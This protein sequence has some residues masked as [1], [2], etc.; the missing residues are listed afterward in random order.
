MIPFAVVF[1]FRFGEEKSSEESESETSSTKS[2]GML[3]SSPESSEGLDTPYCEIFV[4]SDKFG[5]LE[6]E[7]FMWKELEQTFL[8]EDFMV[9]FADVDASF[10]R[11]FESKALDF[12]FAVG[13]S[14]V[15]FF[16]GRPL[17]L[18]GLDA[19][20]DSWDI[21]SLSP[22]SPTADTIDSR[23]SSSSTTMAPLVRRL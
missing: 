6:A 19:E 3:T 17:F 10:F 9:V 12:V 14:S 23:S 8:R 22:S 1:V 16:F 13:R 2:L 20:I 5:L 11:V 21:E 15:S 18:G 7:W 4:S